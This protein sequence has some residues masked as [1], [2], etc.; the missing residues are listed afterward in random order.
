MASRNFN[1]S[2]ISLI[3]QRREDVVKRRLK[4]NVALVLGVLDEFFQHLS[5]RLDAMGPWIVAETFFFLFQKQ[6][7]GG[8]GK[9]LGIFVI[10]LAAAIGLVKRVDELVAE[11]RI[12]RQQPLVHD[13]G[14]RDRENFRRLKIVVDGRAAIGKDSPHA[15]VA[16]AKEF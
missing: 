4:W 13:H 16:G 2:Q 8:E 5:V 6:H 1:H 14:V 9:A 11:P 3:N 7:S 12:G 15:R 10:D